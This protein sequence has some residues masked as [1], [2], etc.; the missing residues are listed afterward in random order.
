MAEPSLEGFFQRNSRLFTIL[1]V[2][3]AISVY[4]TQL[5]LDSRWR[6]LGIVS[7][8]VIFLL[9]S[10]SIQS[11]IPPDSSNQRTFDFIINGGIGESHGL[12][13]FY[14][15][16]YSVILSIIGFILRFSDT[17]IFLLSFICFIIGIAAVREL[18]DFSI[19][20]E[21]S[22]WTIGED[23]EVLGHF[24]RIMRNALIGGTAGLLALS[25]LWIEGKIPLEQLL[26]FQITSAHLAIRIGLLAG[27]VF[28]GLLWVSLSLFGIT[29]HS[30]I[31]KLQEIGALDENG[32]VNEQ[33]FSFNGD[34]LD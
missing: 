7:S 33:F 2:F 12:L 3:G 8:L 29:L 18:V 23:S 22:N 10:V 30:L 11:N 16:F 14:V 32:N 9:V 31:W 15:A 27:A 5:E 26:S 24:L 13:V 1:G 28:G 17:I 19:K 6:R 20:P 4:L 34:E 21:S 25:L